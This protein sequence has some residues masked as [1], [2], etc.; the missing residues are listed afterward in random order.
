[1]PRNSMLP[2]LVLL[3]L[4]AAPLTAA[5]PARLTLS[6]GDH[7]VLVGNTLGE[8]LQ[9][10]NHFETLLH[11][12]FP[13][14]KLVVRNQAWSADELTLRPRSQNFGSPD[15]HLTMAGADVVLGLFGFNESFAGE[16]GLEKFKADL[17]KWIQDTRAKKYNGESA[18]RVALVSPIAAENLG[19]ANLPNGEALNAQLGLYTEAMREVAAELEVPFADVFTPT[20]K[21]FA[22]KENLTF[23]GIH[24]TEAGEEQFAPVLFEALF[25]KAVKYDA[26]GLAP[27]RK[28]VAEKSFQYYHR[29]RAVNGFYIYGGRSNLWKNKEVMERERTI[30]DEMCANRDARIWAVA[31]GNAVPTTIDDSNTSAFLEVETNYKND[32]KYL[33]SEEQLATFKLAEGYEANLFASE[34]MF[35]EL[36]NPVQLSFDARGR[37]WVTTMPSYPQYQPKHELNDRVLILEDTNG[38][39]RADKCTVFAEGLHVPTGIEVGDGG[40]YVAQQPNLVHLKDTNGDDKA[41]TQEIVLHGFDSADSHHSI[42]A[43]TWGPGGALYFQEGTFHHSQIETP[44]GATRLKNAGVFRYEPKTAKLD[45]FVSYGFANPWG[46]TFDRWGQNFVADAS[47]G[48]NYYGTAFSGHVGYDRKHAGMKQFIQKRVR[49]TSGCEFVSSRHFPDEAQGNFLLNNCIGFQGI[50]QHTVKEDQS[51]FVGTEIEPLLVSSDPNFRPVD[52]EF[53]P[54]GA[55]YVVDW[56]NALIGHMQHSLRDP[57]RDMT[58]GRIYRITYKGRPLVEPAKIAGASIPELLELLK[59]YE[60]RTRQ[61]VRTELRNF[62]TAEVMAELD[63]WIAGLTGTDSETQQQLLEALWVCQHHNVVNEKLLRQLLASPEPR[64]RAAATRVLCY[65]RDRVP[66]ALALVEAAVND[67]HPRVRLEAVRAC[68]FFTDPKAMEVALMSLIYPQDDYLKYTLDETVK[69]L[70]SLEK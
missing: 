18:P 5:E 41:D 36:A 56:D 7:V 21:L 10:F 42:S 28:E 25:G 59:T 66:D 43:F 29:Y 20:Q 68:S 3:L 34:E 49:P 65:Q 19:D 9:Y 70:K 61:R 32:I 69:T 38:D 47:G 35:P 52:L 1:M 45:V 54:D 67:E 53:G 6:E 55:L 26:A 4:P 15:Q 14:L 57:K 16:E 60:D 48:A 23:N 51:G 58:H 46:H 24:L 44:Y 8:R 50:L 40:A 2:S 12:Q 30:L 22:G 31:Q 13:E 62:P 64:V 27:L 37:L 11:S 33:S 17:R 39:G 63:K